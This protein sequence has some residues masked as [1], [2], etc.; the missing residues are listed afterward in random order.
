MNVTCIC[1]S[2]NIG[3]SSARATFEN[4]Y[5]KDIE[6]GTGTWIG[7]NSTILPG[8]RIGEGC[9]IAAGSMVN[10]DVPDNCLVGGV[11]AKIIKKLDK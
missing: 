1:F 7:A 10:K 6:I 8:V 11:P 9:V 2:H 4:E 3:G 5:Y